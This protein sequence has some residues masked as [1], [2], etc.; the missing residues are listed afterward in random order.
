MDTFYIF[1]VKFSH[2]IIGRQTIKEV[3]HMKDLLRAISIATF[4]VMIIGW[5]FQLKDLACYAAIASLV[6]TLVWGNVIVD[7]EEEV[8][9]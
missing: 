7:E 3:S 2:S 6:S 5:M 8:L 4:S 9:E 1:F